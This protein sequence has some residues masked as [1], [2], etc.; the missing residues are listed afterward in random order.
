MPGAVFDIVSNRRCLA[1]NRSFT[2]CSRRFTMPY[3]GYTWHKIRHR[4]PFRT[5]IFIAL[6]LFTV[7]FLFAGISSR[8]PSVSVPFVPDQLEDVP[9]EVW[10]ERA[11]EVKHAFVH[12]WNGYE[13]YAAP[14]DELK[15]L[16]R[17]KIDKCVLHC[18]FNILLNLDCAQLQ[19]VGRN[20]L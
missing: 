10:T 6:S 19:R 13:K 7:Y 4:Q 3:R 12:A 17:G 16:S 5:S 1:N 20:P 2:T 11:Q 15:P 18:V 9:L 8:R 14:N